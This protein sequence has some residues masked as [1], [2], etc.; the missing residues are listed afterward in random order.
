[1]SMSFEQLDFATYCIGAVASRLGMS[2]RDAFNALK[3]SGILD[4]YIVPA[5]DSLHT[6]SRDYIVNDF[7][8][9]MRERGVVA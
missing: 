5:Y 3:E 4:G 9:L 1:M 7:V 6:F 2:Q 8:E